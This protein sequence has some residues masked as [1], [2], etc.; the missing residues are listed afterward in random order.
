METT[1]ATSIYLDN[2]TFTTMAS[3][4]STSR[5]EP[6]TWDDATWLLTSAFIIFTMQSGF[7][8]LE[9]G[10]VSSKNEVNIMAK[11]VADVVFG[12]M[13]YWMLGYGLSYGDG[14]GTNGFCGVGKFFLD[15]GDST[16]GQEFS[17]FV[18]QSSF[19]TTAT[20]I[21]SGAIAERTRYLAYI[22]FSF[23]NTFVFC[24][25]AHWV[26][27]E[28]GWLNKMGVIDV[29]GDGPVHLVGGAI[30]LVGTIMIK[31]RAKRFT[32][33]DDHEMGSPSGTLLGLFILW[34][35]WLAFNCGSTY[36]I[37]GGKWKLASRAA[38]T[39]LMAGTS[40]GITGFIG[41]YIVKKRKFLIPW[42]INGVLGGLVSITASCAVT[43]IWES[44]VIGSIGGILVLL[45]NELLIKLHIDDP[46]GSIPVHFTGGIWGLLATG[47]FVHKDT[48]TYN[49]ADSPGLVQG[50]SVHLLGVQALAVVVISAWSICVGGLLL[51]VIDWTVGLRLSPEEEEIGAD[52]AE[53]E[54]R[55]FNSAHRVQHLSDLNTLLELVE[56]GLLS[57]P[58]IRT[59]GIS[60][61]SDPGAN[62]HE[63]TSNNS[64]GQELKH[65][66][67]HGRIWQTLFRHEDRYNVQKDKNHNG[68]TQDSLRAS[69]QMKTKQRKRDDKKTETNADNVDASAGDSN[70]VCTLSYVST[71]GTV[72]N[73]IAHL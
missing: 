70:N 8:L 60:P 38:A 72:E 59:S 54:I 41:S 46:V 57:A 13:S 62:T 17:R 37:S 14:A 22:I 66:R 36:G 65:F 61:M 43:G 25:V 24:I 6:Q 64:P 9:S 2:Q 52:M 49:F 4:M 1:S 44:L 21:V 48:I 47:I 23:F 45:T 56:H 63:T 5:Q 39:T 58:N 31:P 40:G 73:I 16:M 33:V 35:G 68:L 3:D 28:H 30:S 53:H 51:K 71:A 69:S 11:N 26:W 19:A 42:I 20:T 34:W 10:S 12:G 27:S 18:F 50:G 29:A 15:P 67:L 7:G 55:S 32:P